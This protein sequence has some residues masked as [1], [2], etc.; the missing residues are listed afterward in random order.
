M[1]LLQRVTCFGIGL[2]SLSCWCLPLCICCSVSASLSFWLFG[3][4]CLSSCCLSF[5]QILTKGKILYAYPPPPAPDHKNATPHEISQQLLDYSN[6]TMNQSGSST[7]LLVMGTIQGQ[8][9]PQRLSS[10]SSLGNHHHYYDAWY[11][12][13]TSG[14][15]MLVSG[16]YR[17]VMGTVLGLSHLTAR[18]VSFLVSTV[19]SSSTTSA[20]SS[21]HED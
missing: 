12:F 16:T 4:L 13:V 5:L 14:M 8:E 19:T 2:Q 7:Q 20:S 17:L 15:S 6:K 18:T 3:P 21:P 9:L 11:T 10:L 1:A